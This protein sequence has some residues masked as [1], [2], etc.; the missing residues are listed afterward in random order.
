MVGSIAMRKGGGLAT[1][2]LAA[3]LVLGGCAGPG[4]E[5]QRMR[6]EIR[7][8]ALRVA[9]S[10]CGGAGS[11]RFIHPTADYEIVDADGTVL[12]H[13]QLPQGTAQKSFTPDFGDLAEP[14]SCRMEF[15]VDGVD[16]LTDLSIQFEGHPA[17]AILRDE[18]SDDL[19]T[20]V[21]P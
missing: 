21:V 1:A 2:A 18:G 4:A 6:L 7:D 3:V 12:A 8:G 17:I 11:F 20:A 14:T 10:E 9:G 15:T 13:G 5:G 19:P 16:D